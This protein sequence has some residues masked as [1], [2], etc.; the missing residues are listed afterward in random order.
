[1]GRILTTE[2]EGGSSRLA[3]L[4]A[5]ANSIAAWMARWQDMGWEIHGRSLLGQHHWRFIWEQATHRKIYVHHVDAY[6][7]KDNEEATFNAAVDQAAQ[8][9]SATT[10]T[11]DTDPSALAAWAHR[12]GG[13]L[14]GTWRWAEQFG[15]ALTL[16]QCKTSVDNCPICQQVK[17]RD[18]P[19]GPPGHIHRGT[20]AGQVWQIDCIGPLPRQNKKQY[21]LTMVDTYSGVLVAVP[22]ERADQNGTIRGLQHLSSLYG[23]PWEVQSDR[24]SHLA[25]AGIS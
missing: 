13:H 2:G 20:G 14:D 18:W 24:G 17:P 4:A 25:E 10:F 9:S 16:D 6:T 19:I 15:V 3:E 8:I 21:V 7:W 23:V 22:C 12:Q 11:P 5:V 1:M